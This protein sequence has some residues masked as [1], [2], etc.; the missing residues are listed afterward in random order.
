MDN[1]EL[2]KVL[3]EK[4]KNQITPSK[5]FEQKIQNTIKEQKEITKKQSTNSKK[6]RTMKLIVSMA[7][8]ALVAFMI[9]ISLKNEINFEEKILTIATIKDIKPTKSQN[10]ILA[11]DSEF[12]I[13]TEG[14]DLTVESVQKVLYI[15][16]A[17]E[18]TIKKTSNPNEYKLTFEQNIPNNTIVKLQ[19]VK[20][21]IT[22]DSWAY[23][24][25]SELSVNGTYPANKSSYVSRNST[26]EIEF[27]YASVEN[28]EEH[29]EISPA[30]SGTWEHL[31]K[32]WRFTPQNE[33]KEGTYYVKV[34]SGIIA[35][36]KTLKNDYLFEFTVGETTQNEYIYNTISIDRINT[37]K[38]DEQVRIYCYTPYYSEKKLNIS[39]IEIAK[40]G[41]KDEFIEYLQ[42][43]NYKKATNLGEYEFEQTENYVQLT[44]SLQT[45]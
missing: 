43:E 18:Y 8:V 31:G 29:I 40:F 12:L 11:S 20:D 39:K 15:E 28:L 17:L 13:Y 19:Y 3:K 14:E 35:E 34:K 26:I 7:A 27:S 30:T 21:L 33:L 38:P 37:Y 32:V 42:N 10:E 5:E 6:Y 45:G 24:T 9:G 44:E 4:L 22:E 36:Q 1:N 16:P 41:N 25:S 2:D 23:Q